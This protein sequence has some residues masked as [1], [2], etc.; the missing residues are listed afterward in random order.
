MGSEKRNIIIDDN[1]MALLDDNG[2]LITSNMYPDLVTD[3]KLWLKTD[4]GEGVDYTTSG[5]YSM[6]LDRSGLG[7]NPGQTIPSRRPILTTNELNGYAS[8]RFTASSTCYL[9]TSKVVVAPYS[10]YAVYKNINPAGA[11][12]YYN[13]AV[14]GGGS[15]D[16]FFIDAAAANVSRS[17]FNSSTKT[18]PTGAQTLATLGTYVCSSIHISSTGATMYSNSVSMGTNAFATPSRT[19]DSI[20]L[21]NAATNFI[22]DGYIVELIMVGH[23]SSAAEILEFDNYFNTKYAIW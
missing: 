17:V 11:G 9:T 6:P 1:N 13:G 15:T 19:I 18:F 16:A 22:F 3:K 21:G 10:I 14:L 8:Y 7:T 20:G 2:D 12:S 5:G 4:E 23:L